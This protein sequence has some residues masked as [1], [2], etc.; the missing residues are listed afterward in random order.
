MSNEEH[1]PFERSQPTQT[2]LRALKDTGYVIIVTRAFGPN[3][4]DLIDRDGPKFSGEPGIKLRVKQGDIEDEVVL[5]PYYGDPSKIYNAA[6]EEGKACE[7][8]V[9][10]TDIELAKI[11]G[12]SSDDGGDYFA[13]YLTD[14]LEGGELVAINNIWGNYHSQMLSESEM[15]ERFADEMEAGTA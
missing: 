13:I 11:P 1:N 9:A 7:L 5:S 4:E 14:K 2:R 10:G 15:L 3:G 8:F 6:F 12:M